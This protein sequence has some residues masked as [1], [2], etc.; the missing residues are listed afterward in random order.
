[1]DTLN[2]FAMQFS[3]NQLHLFA[4]ITKQVETTPQIERIGRIHPLK[5]LNDGTAER[6]CQKDP[7]IFEQIRL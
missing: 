2:T 1:M 6:F 7:G 3:G 4:K 5:E